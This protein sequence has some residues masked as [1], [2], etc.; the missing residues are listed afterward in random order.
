M[1]QQSGR[2]NWAG[3]ALLALAGSLAGGFAQAEDAHYFVVREQA[4]GALSVASHRFVRLSGKLTPMASSQPGRQQSVLAASM[5]DKKT[6]ASVFD[7][8]AL[9]SP[10]I[11]AEFQSPGQ[12]QIEG[13]VVPAGERQ[14]VLRLPVQAGK[15]LRLKA[16]TLASGAAT[17]VQTGGATAAKAPPPPAVLDIDL[18][19][20]AAPSPSLLRAA[21]PPAVPGSESGLL[22]NNG[23]AA[24]R[25]DLLIVAEGY[26]L[27]QK[28]QFIT[29]ATE[30]A[31]K[32][33]SI[34]PYQDYQ[35]L[36]NVRWLFVPSN[37]S[38]ADKP[39]C[40][41]TPGAEVVMVDTAFDATYCAAGLRRLLV[42]DSTKV[43]TAAAD[44]PD[45][46]MVAVLVNDEE[47]GGSGGYISVSSTN[48]A[49]ADVM[50]H[51]LGHSF[52]KLADEYD[53]PYPS[54]PACSDQ[55]GTPLGACEANV[56]DQTVR[57]SL[58]WKRWVASATPI[59]SVAPMPDPIEAGLWQGARYQSS[60]MYRQ[61]FS[62]IMRSLGSPFCHVDGEAFVKQLFGGGWGAPSAGVSLIEPGALPA[63]ASVTANVGTPLGF[64]A[65]VAGSANNGGLTAT[66]LVDQQPVK[67]VA[68][69]HGQWQTF[70]YTVA[71]SA[72]HTI[73]FKVKDNTPLMLDAP[74]SSKAWAVQ[75]V[76]VLPGA[77]TIT[78]L[79][80]SWY[81]LKL[82]FTPPAAVP[83]AVITG[84][85]STCTAPSRATAIATAS[86]SPITMSWLQGGVTYTCTVVAKSASGNGPASAP[87][88]AKTL[89]LF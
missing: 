3:G 60:G 36:I 35:Q 23:D 7:T 48:A 51:E 22:I 52:S 80:A 19:Q 33:L 49:S 77:P 70:S 88:S 21:P 12:T 69:Q 42:A 11:R 9:G 47:Y 73:E 15:L 1:K 27:A 83:G 64:Q 79:T 32:F 43:P 89:K 78:A 31:H 82:S 26:T 67:T 10:W 39:D 74:T 44:V 4:N 20:Y 72:P 55:P 38:G 84:Y 75:G 18:D 25:L 30:L 29:Q 34:S 63:T 50:Q 8:Q 62:G 87:R 58:K 13:R 57:S 81:S 45:W 56:T 41:E 46:D 53:S 16:N 37:Q 59:P 85:T 6:G 71:D 61:C 28:A 54:Y 40:G 66:W 65:T 5:V 86:K 14:Y 68:T 24:N 2:F 17:S 76:A